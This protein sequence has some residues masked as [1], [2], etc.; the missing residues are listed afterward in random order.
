MTLKVFGCIEVEGNEMELALY[1]AVLAD[2]LRKMNE[3]REEKAAAEEIKLADFFKNVS[4]EDLF[5]METREEARDSD[6]PS[7]DDVE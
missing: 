6:D 5:R 4:F 1:T 2:A 7:E 3:V